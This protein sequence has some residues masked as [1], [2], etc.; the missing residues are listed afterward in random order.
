MPPLDSMMRWLSGETPHSGTATSN[1]SLSAEQLLNSYVG[2]L[3]KKRFPTWFEIAHA[4]RMKD[5]AM[6]RSG[7]LLPIGDS[8]SEMILAV[9]LLKRSSRWSDDDMESAWDLVPC[10]IDAG[11]EDMADRLIHAVERYRVHCAAHL[12]E[13]GEE[14]D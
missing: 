7:C 4:L 11:K 8:G 13:F 1:E 6:S 2:A 5:L 12:G 9:R 14:E 3:P 10:M